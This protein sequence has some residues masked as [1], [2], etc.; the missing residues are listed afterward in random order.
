MFRKM[1]NF[2]KGC[3]IHAIKID[4]LGRSAILSY[5]TIFALVPLLFIIT[6]L[7]NIFVI[8][9]LVKS[10]V[11][12]LVLAHVGVINVDY[13]TGSIKLFLEKAHAL[14]PLG[15]LFVFISGLLLFL[16][17][18]SVFDRVW[19]VKENRH[20]YISILIYAALMLFLPLLLTCTVLFE[21]YF[22]FFSNPIL[23]SFLLVLSSIILF[24][25]IY[26]FIPS[27]SVDIKCALIGAIV[28]C[29]MNIGL[30]HVFIFYFSIFTSYNVIYGVFAALPIF[31]LW[32][33]FSWLVIIFGAVITY[34]NE[35][36]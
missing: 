36:V 26:K 5:T 3:V 32:I 18:E 21:Y 30:K 28:A 34:E 25:I 10:K 12:Q 6:S 29:I 35:K 33:Y 11:E 17:I 1:Y 24:T 19:E 8:S 14:S 2:L 13:I 23:T 9:E 15:I 20:S 7:L 27:C 16:E 31:M 22:P 4:C